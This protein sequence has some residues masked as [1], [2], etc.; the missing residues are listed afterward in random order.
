MLPPALLNVSSRVLGQRILPHYVTAQDEPWLSALLD[1]YRRFVGE[2]H[3]ALQERLREPLAL[4]APKI[5]LRIVIHVL[6]Q[7]CFQRAASVVPPKEA[8]SAVFRQA[9]C[10][11][12]SRQEVLSGVAASF[13]TSVAELDASLFADLRSERRVGA[14]PEHVSPARLAVAANLAIASSLIRRA[15]RVQIVARGNARALVR[16]AQRVGLICKISRGNEADA[17]MLDVSG[18]FALFR[19]TDV[20]GRALASLLPRLASCTEFELSAACALVHGAEPATLVVRSGDPIGNGREL[21]AQERRLEARFERAF[22]R[23]APEWELIAEPPPV[24]TGDALLFPD[25]E[26]VHRRDPSRRFWLEI[27]GFWTPGYLLEKFERLRAAG[28]ERVLLCVDQKRLCAELDSCLASQV[29]R[30]KS[31]IDPLAVLAIIEARSN[32]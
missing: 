21:A 17:L 27:V 26:L 31:R 9:A 6:D 19:H 22:R 12:V 24:Q 14:L 4:R 23:A 25:F 28:L 10:R 8:R 7:L 5:K 30:Y 20:Y 16:H 13:G 15:A 29:I 1:E 2:K 3:S 18:P 32:S 11:P